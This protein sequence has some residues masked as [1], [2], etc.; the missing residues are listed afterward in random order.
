MSDTHSLVTNYDALAIS[1]RRAFALDCLAAGIEAAHPRR[2]IR[3]AVSLNDNVLRIRESSYDLSEF[4]ELI[5]LGGGK[6]GGQ[7]AV[8]LESILGEQLDGGLVVTNDPSESERVEIRD[9]DHPVPSEEG[10]EN[11]RSLLEYARDADED[12]LVL[13]VITGGGSALLSAPA[14]GLGIEDLQ[15][16][17]TEL[18]E[19]GATIHEINA[20]RKHLSELKGGLL[21]RAV[22]PATAVGL[23][24]SDVV[25]ND[26]DV[27]ASGPL[28][29]DRSTYGDAIAVLDR[30]D[31]TVPDV[32]RTRLERGVDGALPETPKPDDPVFERIEHHIVA[33]GMTAIDAARGRA[34]ETA[35]ETMVLSSRIRGESREAAK[36]AAAITE[37]VRATGNP[38]ASPAVL[39][40]GGET[41]VTVSGDGTG[42]ANQEYA[43]GCAA[44]LDLDGVTIA[45]VDT[46]GID[47]PTDAAGA[48]VDSS[49][50]LD[51]TVRDA[52]NRN[53]VYP[54]LEQRGELVF[55]GKTGTNVNDLRVVVIDP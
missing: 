27:I 31:V 37:E 55:T 43:L 5:V 1:S 33:D 20:V 13:G 12:T 50:D 14:D 15:K 8:E 34:S 26:L 21:A 29:P 17:T 52:L 40:S 18:L 32:V 38:I 47:G 11:T 42:G 45:A 9:G 30:Y 44:E 35:Y 39:I 10:V 4:S 23:V 36:T 19:S 2:V 22:G 24:F 3:D 51:E 53:D 28:V 46:D 48:L 41:T 16:T 54:L 6:A 7:V 25:G 49:L